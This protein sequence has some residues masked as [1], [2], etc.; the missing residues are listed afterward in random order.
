M[1]KITITIDLPLDLIHELYKMAIEENTV[2]DEVINRIL[3]EEIDKRKCNQIG[4]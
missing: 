1:K 4:D 2:I 3:K